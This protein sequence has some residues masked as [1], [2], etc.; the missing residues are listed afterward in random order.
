M[1][2]ISRKTIDDLI[3]LINP[4]IVE[5]LNTIGFRDVTDRYG[6]VNGRCNHEGADNPT[7]F[8]YHK[9]MKIWSCFTK[10][11][12][13]YWGPSLVGLTRFGLHKLNL[14]NNFQDAIKHMAK[15]LDSHGHVDRVTI[16][17]EELDLARKYKYKKIKK[18]HEKF[19][20]NMMKSLKPK[21]DYLLGRGFKLDS[22]FKFKIGFC[23]NKNNRFNNR[24]VIPIYNV[25]N[26][27]TGFTGRWVGDAEK[28]KV[29]KWIHSRGFSKREN[30][31]NLNSAISF[32]KKSGEVILTEGP[33]DVI[34]LDEYGVKN[35]VAIFGISLSSIQ[36]GIVLANSTSVILA[37][38][39]DD[40]GDNAKAHMIKALKNYSDIY[41]IKLPKGK[42][43]DELSA[44]EVEEVFKAKER[45]A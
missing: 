16:R 19:N 30:L 1:N 3:E 24:I 40:A 33:L 36:K 18:L 8:S 44:E 2:K 31:F 12:E 7:A 9:G 22:I 6:Y 17:N 10:H 11:C 45:V 37:M 15:F 20:D 25:S 5:Y 38:D 41:T 43:F 32:I 21:N 14:P 26:E 23:D 35:A 27:M 4:R 29:S 28:D 42:D 13:K 34:K 39:S